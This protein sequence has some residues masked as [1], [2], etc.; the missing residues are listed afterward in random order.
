MGCDSET[1]IVNLAGSNHY[2]SGCD[3]NSSWGLCT[4]TWHEGNYINDSAINLFAKVKI[5]NWSHEINAG[6]KDGGKCYKCCSF[7][8]CFTKYWGLK[9][10]CK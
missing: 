4:E 5:L 10:E 7:W 8:K 6:S 3:Y 1:Y 9:T 2:R